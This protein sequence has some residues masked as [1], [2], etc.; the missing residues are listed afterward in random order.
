MKLIKNTKILRKMLILCL[1]IGGLIF[2]TSDETVSASAAKDCSDANNDFYGAIYE[3]DAVAISYSNCLSGCDP[4]NPNYQQ[5]R[6]TCESSH[7]GRFDYAN[8]GI[9][10]AGGD[11]DTCTN[12]VPD[13]CGEARARNDSC[14]ATF[15][16][17]Q[18]SD[19]NERLEIYTAY[20]N[21]TDASGIDN[22][23]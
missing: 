13:Y 21:C 23:E 18:Y 7:R 19:P 17:S 12:P 22:C 3:L 6:N 14:R 4:N 10:N 5:C 1:L 2:V 9:L 8:L 11:L 15:N 16:Y 20:L